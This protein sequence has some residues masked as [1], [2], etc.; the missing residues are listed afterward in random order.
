ML[1]GDWSYD[2]V[3]YV[4]GQGW[5]TGV[6]E[7]EFAPSDASTRA[8]VVEV[9]YRMAGSPT[10]AETGTYTDVAAGSSYAGAVA[11][12]QAN[13]ITRGVSSNLFRPE[14]AVTREQFVTFLYRYALYRSMNTEGRDDL[15]RYTDWETVSGYA[16]NPM[17][18][19]SDAGIIVGRSILLAPHEPATR[20]EIATMLA[21]FCAIYAL[22]AVSGPIQP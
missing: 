18:W 11:W 5:M 6:T 16:E 10:F 22:D 9:L 15:S 21:R 20:A 3:A 14:E 17:Q 7:T 2:A 19:A 1:P 4:F 13:G 8:A 12:A